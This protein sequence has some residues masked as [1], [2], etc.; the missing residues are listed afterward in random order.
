MLSCEICHHGSHDSWLSQWIYDVQ[1][2]PYVNN[3]HWVSKTSGLFL[4][5]LSLFLLWSKNMLFSVFHVCLDW[6][7]PPVRESW[8][9][10]LN[11]YNFSSCPS[12]F[13]PGCVHWNVVGATA[14]SMEHPA[15]LQDYPLHPPLPPRVPLLSLSL[16]I[17]YSFYLFIFF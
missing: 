12:F 10:S 17:F 5:I 8:L 3:N 11:M 4:F 14:P 1:S 7:F 9:L 13:P 16:S 2:H 15:N 6:A